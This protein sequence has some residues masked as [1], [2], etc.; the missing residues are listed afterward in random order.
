MF[1]GMLNN[2]FEVRSALRIKH[3]WDYLN[4][5]FK[6]KNNWI[7]NWEPWQL[8]RDHGTTNAAIDAIF[9]LVHY[10]EDGYE[11][12]EATESIVLQE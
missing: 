3:G 12:T 8:F 6:H 2:G 11:L 10:V 1:D 5:R 9:E 7:E 4:P